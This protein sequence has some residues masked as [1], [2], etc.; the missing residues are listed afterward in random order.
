MIFGHNHALTAIANTYGDTYIDNIPTCGVVI[1][2]FNISNWS[3]L[4]PGKIVKTI[5]PRDFK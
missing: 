2:K 5:F 1:I 4:A 3:Q